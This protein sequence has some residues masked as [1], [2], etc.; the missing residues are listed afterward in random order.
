MPDLNVIALFKGSER[1]IFVYDDDSRADVIAAFRN[2]AADP[3]VAVTW[4]DAA[5]MTERARLQG[6]TQ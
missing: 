6:V 4:S 3:R 1:F 5:V 2:A